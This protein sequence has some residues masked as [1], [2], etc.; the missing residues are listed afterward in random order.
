LPDGNSFG[1]GYST[2]LSKSLKKF[3]IAAIPN[4]SSIEGITTYTTWNDLTTTIRAIIKAERGTDNQVWVNTPGLDSTNTNVLLNNA[5]DHSDHYYSAKAAQDAIKDSLWVGIN[6]FIDYRSASL[7]PNLDANNHENATGAFGVYLWAMQESLY[8]G[9]FESSHKNWL[10]MDYFYVKRSPVGNA[11]NVKITPGLTEIPMIVSITTPAFLYKEITALISPY[12]VGQLHTLV[13]D[14]NDKLIFE[15]QTM[16][17]SRAPLLISLGT[18]FTTPGIYLVK[19]ILNNKYVE[20][21]KIS[22]Q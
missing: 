13:Y 11:A 8:N 9:F 7:T 19:N 17:E 16:V 4:I 5:N 3:F 14:S 21:K 15:K 2:T 20:S 6:E 22:V 1:S 10:P 18:P 12:E